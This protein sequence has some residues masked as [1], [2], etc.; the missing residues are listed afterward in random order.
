MRPLIVYYSYSGNNRTLALYLQKKLQ[1][2]AMAIQEYRPRKKMTIF[3]DV[4]LHRTPR[5]SN[6]ERSLQDYDQLILVAPVWA[7]RIATPLKTYLLQQYDAIR[8]F[9]LITVCGGH[10]GQREKLNAELIRLTGKDPDT[11]T[12]LALTSL[13]AV[14]KNNIMSYQLT[15]DDLQTF[16][17]AIKAFLEHAIKTPVIQ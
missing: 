6:P 14:N 16:A 12:E 1:C 13:P 15:G 11:V 10:A 17:P 9:S 7:G 5:I 3:L 2:D 8:S 4:F